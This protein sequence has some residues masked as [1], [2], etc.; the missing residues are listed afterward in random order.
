MAE[1]L[2]QR[3]APVNSATM[4]RASIWSGC[5]VGRPGALAFRGLQRPYGGGSSVERL[6]LRSI[7]FYPQ[8]GM[9]PVLLEAS[10]R[11][12]ESGSE[13]RLEAFHGGLLAASSSFGAQGQGENAKSV[14][15]RPKGSAL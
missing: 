12:V 15:A 9:A 5:G 10:P 6:Y 2:Q 3:N 8:P 14:A 13:L 4:A 7:L 11:P 1:C